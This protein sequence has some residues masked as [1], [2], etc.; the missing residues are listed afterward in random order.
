[1][2]YFKI[3]SSEGKFFSKLSGDNNQIHLNDL[4]GYNSI[5]GEK[6]CHG[7]LVT[8]KTFKAINL[9]KV[10]NNAKRYTIKIIFFK[11][12]LYNQKIKIVEKNYTYKL[13]QQNQLIAK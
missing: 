6:I 13:I 7:S 4:T 5:F 8:L 10:I 12:F 11:H 2:R 3:L 1:M 9:K